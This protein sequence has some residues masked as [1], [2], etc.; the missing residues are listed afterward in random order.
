M[1]DYKEIL[2]EFKRNCLSLKASEID[3]KALAK[4]FEIIGKD[5]KSVLKGRK[6]NRNLNISK[7]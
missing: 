3:K 1:M 6:L 2:W 5:I 4:D 7:L